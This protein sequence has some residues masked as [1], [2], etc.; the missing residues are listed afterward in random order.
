MRAAPVASV[1]RRLPIGAELSEHGV[2][3]RVWAPAHAKLALAV[4][5]PPE[6]EIP[7]RPEPGG[8][9][10]VFVEGLGAGARYRFRAGDALR[11]DPASRFQPDGPFGASEVI[12]PVDHAWTDVGWRGITEPYRQV[13]YELHVGTF[14]REG[15]WAA[16]I[17]HL[18]RL[19]ELGITTVEM[20]PVGDF[21]GR[22]G[23]GYDGVDLFAPSRL[24]GT[25]AEL[26]RFVDRAHGL[27]L[28]VLLDVVYNHLGPAGNEL[29]ELAPEFRR[30][31]ATGEWGDLLD[32]SRRGVRDFFV[33][34][35]AYWID[36]FH[37]DGLRLDAT[38]AIL[39]HGEPHILAE[40]VHRARTAAGARRIFIVAENEPQD[41]ALVAEHGL[42]ALWNDD[43]EHTSR[44][45]LTG[46]TDGYLHDYR[47]APQEL[48][49]AVLRGFLYQGQIYAWQRNPRGTPTTGLPPARFVH[50]LENH[51]QI[52]NFACGR[53]LVE[54]A[55]PASLRAMTALLL[56]GPQ[57]PMLFQGQEYGSTR[58]WRF[59]ADHAGDLAD[60]VRTGRA[61][62]GR[63]FERLAD[64]AM[65]EELGDP[66]APARFEACVLEPIE[67]RR[68]G[69]W[70][71]LHRD[72]LAI[73]RADPTFTDQRP[74]I[75]EGAVLGERAFCLRWHAP[76]ADRLL[77]VNLGRTMRETVLPE[78]L[79]APPRDTGWRAAWSSEHPRYGGAGT[80][81]PFTRARLALPARAAV[82]CVPDA[83]AALR[84]EPS[85]PA[86]DKEPVV[87]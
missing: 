1:A 28:A 4:G 8:Y 53:R 82:L 85:P 76:A 54:L 37:L 7:M 38:Q 16:A 31:N 9:H 56:L 48:V 66:N 68:A 80:P 59:F 46:V 61:A 62:F 72:L 35:A 44:V 34:N 78:P 5:D 70:L 41:T 19:A 69:P 14:T 36:E 24:Y 84:A 23:W 11:A 17:E 77:L 32:F 47:G 63:Q 81:E 67:Q 42:D 6:R 74:G 26:R 49:S 20:M 45:A 15:T 25:P 57:L 50:Y 73:R 71:E 13:I 2:H 3:F 86:G 18:P 55:D 40:L 58:R 52:A 39:D 29:F 30:A 21:A 10:A 79:L 83:G 65:A 22:R 64:P 51:D 60:A 12:D 27:G 87:P 43:F 33:A 75:L